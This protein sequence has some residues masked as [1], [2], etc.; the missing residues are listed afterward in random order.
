MNLT[1]IP[2]K[3]LNRAFFAAG[4]LLQVIFLT[5]SVVL[6][7]ERTLYA[8]TAH[9]LA[10]ISGS[11]SF[12]LGHRLIAVLSRILPV[13]AS[14]LG[15]SIPTSMILYSVNLA[16]MFIL[17]YLLI[18]YKFRDRKMA[19]VLL[20]FQFVFMFRTFY[21]PI[22]ELQH[23]LVFLLVYW[24]YI[25]YL[26]HRE[27]RP[28]G[29]MMIY[30]IL[31]IIMNTHPIILF[32]FIASCLILSEH[33]GYWHAEDQKILIPIGAL[34]YVISSIVFYTKY[35][36]AILA[37]TLGPAEHGINIY[38]IRLMISTLIREY[39]PT[40]LVGLI[41]VA[42]LMR[43]YPWKKA[44]VIFCFIAL[45]FLFVY[46]RFANTTFT[47][48]FFE[49]YLLPMPFMLFLIVAIQLHHFSRKTRMICVSLLL[50]IMIFQGFR[51]LEHRTFY[52]NRLDI[53]SA[54]FDKMKEQGA[55]K[56][57]LPFYKAP[58]WEI[59]DFYA[60]PFETYLL[61]YTDDD[62]ENDGF[63]ISY[64]AADVVEIEERT[65]HLYTFPDDTLH[66]SYPLLN[67]HFIALG[68]DSLNYYDFKNYPNFKFD[69]AP[70]KTF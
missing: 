45:N 1:A 22:S 12:Y 38:Y 48:S 62:P 7:R 23:G 52:Q 16:L 67:D 60:S 68:M 8:D 51:V 53:Y 29:N 13:S 25:F 64:L 19:L 18:A 49:I 11:G 35:E 28:A 36:A 27:R 9:F 54:T 14:Y 61:S 69:P 66:F 63:I 2:E 70:Y 43:E 58:M 17:P 33:E 20:L 21:L 6:Y 39:Y 26:N 46:L 55:S 32:A 34:L 10:E 4:L 65:I 59:V 24:S 44:L 56:V 15:V 40:H 41:G 50:G 30:L 42:M 3:K 37:Q 57:I 31:I 47:V 5:V